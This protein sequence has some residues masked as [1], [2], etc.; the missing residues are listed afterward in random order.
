MNR[1]DQLLEN[2]RSHIQMPLRLGLPASQRV[3]FA[4]YPA[5]EERRLTNRVEEFEMITKEAG[6]PWVRIDL[7]GSLARWLAS[8][9]EEDRTKWFINPSVIESYAKSEWKDV[10]TEFFNKEVARAAAPERTVFALTG[11]MDLY[12][13]LHVSELIDGLEKTFPGYLL[14]FFPGEKEGNTYRFLDARTGWN[15]LAV[16]ILSEK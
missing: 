8:V 10:L 12:D 3:W 13:F 4:V 6:H 5:E 14:V 11:L 16:P 15:Y 7:K 9:D 2:Y 1:I